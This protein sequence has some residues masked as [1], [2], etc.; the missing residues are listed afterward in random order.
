MALPTFYVAELSDCIDRAKLSEEETK[1][2][3]RVRR[4]A[5]GARLRLF[6]GRGTVAT[7]HLLIES[8]SN[9]FVELDSIRT[10]DS[11]PAD[12]FIASALP[13]GDRQ[14]VMIDMITQ[15]GVTGFIPLNC[16]RST[17]KFQDKM[18]MKWQR[19]S[20][21]ACKQSQNP[22]ILQ[23][24]EFQTVKQ[25]LAKQS[26][27]YY[28]D[29]NGAQM[30]AKTINSPITLIIGPEGGFSDDELRLL[31]KCANGSLCLGDHILRT[32]TAAVLA[33]GTIKGMLSGKTIVHSR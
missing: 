14:R 12:L 25:L 27:C 13:K 31:K 30:T 11:V 6:D 29:K 16:E 17:V 21:E 22:F 9:A 20:I 1:H 10:I 5:Q 23:C 2:A 3:L 24:H 15:I 8:K 32:E 4:L 19:Y 26:H 28:L 7:G 33:A 18:L